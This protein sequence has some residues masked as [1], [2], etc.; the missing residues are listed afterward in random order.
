MLIAIKDFFDENQVNELPALPIKF[1]LSS[2]YDL[3]ILGQ[4]NVSD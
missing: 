3:D 2:C 1:V 4:N